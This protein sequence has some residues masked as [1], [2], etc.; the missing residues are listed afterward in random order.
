MQGHAACGVMYLLHKVPYKNS[1]FFFAG[2]CVEAFCEVSEAFLQL[3][4]AGSGRAMPKLAG[5]NL[6]R[7]CCVQRSALPLSSDSAHGTSQVFGFKKDNGEN[8][9]E[10][11]RREKGGRKTK[12]CMKICSLLRCSK[13]S[14]STK[15]SF[16]LLTEHEQ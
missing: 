10:K 9:E 12:S 15:F 2:H 3:G 6:G 4:A 14:H 13:R 8:R 11:R 1:M 5:T 7:Q 16:F